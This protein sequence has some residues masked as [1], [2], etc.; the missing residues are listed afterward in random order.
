[1]TPRFLIPAGLVAAALT[2]LAAYQ[3]AGYGDPNYSWSTLCECQRQ[4]AQA[5]ARQAQ[6]DAVNR[7]AA[8]RIALRG[9]LCREL[10]D[11][12]RDLIETA[13][14]FN[15]LNQDCRGAA[16]YVQQHPGQ[17]D[18][19]KVCRQVSGWTAEIARD[20]SEGLADEVRR[21]LE[22]DLDRYLREHGTGE[23]PAG[24]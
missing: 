1:P 21:R 23:L 7:D 9:Q 2:A 3:L 14:W 20:R 24:R 18:G 13:A 4:I 6:L 19:E 17:S 10:I 16:S 5:Q 8:R 15:Y 11:G 12:R 22:A